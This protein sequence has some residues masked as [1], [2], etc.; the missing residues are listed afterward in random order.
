MEPVCD[1]QEGFSIVFFFQCG[2]FFFSG[3]V[4]ASDTHR[5]EVATCLWRGT[6]LV[7]LD[8]RVG[9]SGNIHSESIPCDKEDS[10]NVARDFVYSRC[11]A[12]LSLSLVW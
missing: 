5:F 4:L 12:S 2:G 10:T 8:S 3:G 9:A 1:A 7:T 6:R 11:P